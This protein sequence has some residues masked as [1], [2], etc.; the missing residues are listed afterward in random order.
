MPDQNSAYFSRSLALLR[1]DQGWLKPLLVLAAAALVPIV[2]L[3]GVQGYALEW[4]RLTAWGV[5]SAPKQKEVRVGECIK[6]G[7]RG[8]VAGVGYV[9]FAGVING[10]LANL[11]G[12]NVIT[13]ILSIAVSLIGSIAYTV[14]AL[15]AT[16]YQDFTAGYRFDRMWEL[17]SR[18]FEGLSKI[19]LIN[20]A[21]SLV[22]GIVTSLLGMLILIPTILR[23]AFEVEGANLYNTGFD[24]SDSATMRYLLFGFIDSLVTA[25]PWL[26]IL[27]YLS[28]IGGTFATLITFTATGLWMRNFNVAAWGASEDPL[29]V[30][31]GLPSSTY[32]AQPTG[33]EQPY[34]QQPTYDQQTWTEP[35][36]YDQQMW[37]QPQSYD[38]QPYTQAQDQSQVFPM[39]IPMVDVEPSSNDEIESVRVTPGYGRDVVEVVDLTSG[40]IPEAAPVV[41]D[42]V[43]ESIHPEQEP[44]EVESVQVATIALDEAEQA[45]ETESEAET[46]LEPE[47]ENKPEPMVDSTSEQ[48]PDS[49]LMDEADSDPTQELEPLPA[50]DTDPEPVIESEPESIVIPEPV[51]M[52]T[53][54]RLVVPEVE[55]VDESEAKET[56]AEEQGEA[57]SEKAE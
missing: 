27:A 15:R 6:S 54:G 20:V 5:D 34:T 57:A 2:G 13:S 36:P 45:I 42:D 49:E 21:I 32:Y 28:S 43:V 35:Q 53:I 19:L 55:E 1:K 14:A 41:T 3:L 7:W 4:A 56:E 23:W 22:V 17:V 50:V 51:S 11:L 10:L 31:N 46:E 12:D 29:P 38:Q 33:Y 39:P 47:T 16:I 26:A 30:T 48:E 24:Y 8:F 25:S 18:D 37:D 52:P 9:I 40:A 44:T